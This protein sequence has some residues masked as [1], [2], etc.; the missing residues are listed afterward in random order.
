MYHVGN[1]FLSKI[2]ATVDAQ[3]ETEQV[4]THDEAIVRT[5]L[6]LLLIIDIKSKFAGFAEFVKPKLFI[7]NEYVFHKTSTSNTRRN[8]AIKSHIWEG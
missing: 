4:M 2:D 3:I 5:W 1:S 7:W 8:A 6:E